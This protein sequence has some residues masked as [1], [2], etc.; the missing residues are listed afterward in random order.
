MVQSST[1]EVYLP[2]IATELFHMFTPDQFIES[3]KTSL[4][5]L[6]DLS[7][8]AFEGVEKL[9]DLNVQAAK[10][11]LIESHEHAQA[12]LSVKDVQEFLALQSGVVE[13][14]AEKVAA[15]NRHL[16]DIASGVS[17]EFSKAYEAR[18]AE[19]Q[20]QFTAFIE[21]A[22]KNAPAGSES[23]VALFKSAVDAA[24]NAFDSV[25]KAAKQ[26]SDIAEANINAAAANATKM[27]KSAAVGGKKR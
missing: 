4:K 15:Y 12:L 23:A 20:A 22:A 11:A 16:Y 9:I 24:N 8:K 1:P 10:S 17:N 21:D 27:T 25:Q 6:N 18:V 5:T 3:Q 2:T 26:A 19:G 14:L 7:L 13:P